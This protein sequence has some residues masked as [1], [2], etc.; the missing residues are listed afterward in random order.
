MDQIKNVS[1]EL[2]KINYNEAF[3]FN[4]LVHAQQ[5]IGPMYNMQF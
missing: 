3:L 1:L 5:T 2:R 4:V